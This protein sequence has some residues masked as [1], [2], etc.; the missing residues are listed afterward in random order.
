MSVLLE[1]LAMCRRRS[2]PTYSSR[3]T[4]S[5]IIHRFRSVAFIILLYDSLYPFHSLYPPLVP[6]SCTRLLYPPLVPASCISRICSGLGDSPTLYALLRF[7][8][9]SPRPRLCC[10]VL[11]SL[12]RSRRSENI[13]LLRT[14]AAP[15]AAR[16]STGGLGRSHGRS[17]E[18]R[19]RRRGDKKRCCQQL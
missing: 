10:L 6:A 7:I 4:P 8:R 9:C 14:L 15:L 13:T 1:H 5:G 18:S 11:F 19:S 12:L 17:F 16:A 3:C 2:V